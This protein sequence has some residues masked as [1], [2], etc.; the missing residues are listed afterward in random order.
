MIERKGQA[1]T[2]QDGKQLRLLLSIIPPKA[3]HTYKAP[4]DLKSTKYLLHGW[5]FG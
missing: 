5:G 1:T 4:V 2:R 3:R